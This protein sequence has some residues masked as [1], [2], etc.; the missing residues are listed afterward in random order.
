MWLVCQND[1]STEKSA[2]AAKALQKAD[3]GNA[4]NAWYVY[5]YSGIV[6]ANVKTDAGC[7][8]PVRGGQ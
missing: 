4:S 3:A 6:S 1:R 2:T 7:V 5:L 8:L